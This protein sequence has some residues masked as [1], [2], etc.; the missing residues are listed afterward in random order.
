MTDLTRSSWRRSPVGPLLLLLGMSQG[1]GTFSRTT[2]AA[3]PAAAIEASAS[4]D[5]EKD[6]RAILAMA[7]GYDVKFEFLETVAL[8][9]GYKLEEPYRV[10]ATELVIVAE[11]TPSKVVLQH[12][13]A[14]GKGKDRKSLKH[15]RQD[16]TFEA[17]EV[18]EYRGGETWARRSLSESQ[19]R[20][21]WTQQVFGIEDGPRYGSWGP[22]VHQGGV[23]TWTSQ[24]TWRPLPRREEDRDDYDV[25]VGINR[26]TITPTGWMHE[27]DNGKLVLRGKDKLLARERGIIPYNKAPAEDFSAVEKSWNET[28]PFWRDVRAAWEQVINSRERISFLPSAKR[29]RS[30]NSDLNDLREKAL[31]TSGGAGELKS[32]A[33]ETIERH[34]TSESQV[35]QHAP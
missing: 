30:L 7:G 22:W 27:Q 15:W 33:V 21:A 16:W 12:I 28:A 19:R 5:P 34:L 1:C 29:P 18:L 24:D 35:A 25:I 23:S 4:C 3:A 20:C 31:A 2:P 32:R 11:D 8:A 10:G 13:L 17:K 9:E 14:M 6:R 26:H